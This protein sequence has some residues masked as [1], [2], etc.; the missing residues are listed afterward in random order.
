MHCGHVSIVG[1]PNVGKS[2][3]LNHLIG[4]KISI[5]SRKPQT[6]RHHVLGIKTRDD[7]QIIYLDTPG[8]QLSP[9]GSL[10]R[11]MNREAVNAL[12]DVDLIIFMIDAV[13]WTEEDES[14]WSKIDKVSKVK[15]LLV[16]NKVDKIRDKRD[17]MRLIKTLSEKHDFAEI[18]PLSARQLKD[19][20]RLE[21]L[22]MPYLP[23]A[24]SIYPENQITNRSSRFLAAEFIREKLMQHL[25][26][27]LPYKLAV[28][29]DEFRE[30]SRCIRIFATIWVELP[31]QKKII[32]GKNGAVLKIVG[33]QAR[34][35]LEKLFDQKVFL[36]TWVKIKR[37]WTDDLQALKSFDLG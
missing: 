16:I 10:N 15:R 35:D 18:I 29:I 28:T 20:V 27:E 37:K 34:K 3:L 13:G 4:Q 12:S 21:K 22:L 23:V 17:I 2:T 7:A 24:D 8:F 9:K 33:E 31:G 30:T 25:G 14:V 19:T 32:I 11:F 5:T 36:K 1:R 6:T 26:D